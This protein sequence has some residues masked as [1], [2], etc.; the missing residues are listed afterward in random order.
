MTLVGIT[1]LA[2]R[3]LTT[4]QTTPS[5]WGQLRK[6]AAP[7]SPFLRYCSEKPTW[8]VITQIF[9]GLGWIRAASSKIIDNT[10]WNGDHI[11]HFAAA[12]E[13][14]TLPWAQLIVQTATH[15][16]SAFIAALVLLAQVFTG[17]ALVTNRFLPT[18]LSVGLTMNVVFMI[19]G[20]VNP[21]VFYII[22][23][24]ALALW[25]AESAR[26]C[27]ATERKLKTTV[28]LAGAL[29]LLT[30]PFIRTVHPSHV[31]EDPA[32]VLALVSAL[33]I[34]AMLIHLT[35]LFRTSAPKP[36]QGSRAPILITPEKTGNN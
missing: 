21:S 14:H 10:W 35:P 12:H 13:T 19:C 23:Q 5:V 30:A 7:V 4:Q 32:C 15:N 27:P 2:K 17:V 29:L 25:L 6:W 18:A 36:T 22:G 9:F 11:R 31:I 26:Y 34:L 1:N 8:I 16:A 28:W 3:P 33:T 20:A 24:G